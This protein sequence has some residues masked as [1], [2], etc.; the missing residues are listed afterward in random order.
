[1]IKYGVNRNTNESLYNKSINVEISPE[2][3][4]YF[5]FYMDNIPDVVNI[6][7]CDVT[8]IIDLFNT[9]D[10]GI[11]IQKVLNNELVLNIFPVDTTY[12]TL[13]ERKYLIG[14]ESLFKRKN[15]NFYQIWFDNYI[16]FKYHLGSTIHEALLY[17]IKKYR[18]YN[19][20]YTK[21][22]KH[23][24]SL[25][26][27]HTPSREI[28]YNFYNSLNQ[29][30]KE[31]FIC[32]F[33]FKNIFLENKNFDEVFNNF[34]LVF[35]ESIFPYY[36]S[37]LIEI[38]SESSRVAVTE[39]SFK[40][41]LAGVPFIWWLFENSPQSSH[42]IQIFNSIG[43]DTCYFNI[44][45]SDENNIKEKINELLLLSIDEIKIKYKKDFEKAEE[46]KIKVFDYID[47][48]TNDIIK[49]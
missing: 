7:Y 25:N 47:G 42:Q 1:M 41:L 44:D 10:G 21:K 20:D 33:R 31:K 19:F 32:S 16:Q 36:D 18:N 2:N 40:P 11:L 24:L 38:V 9:I 3:E 5:D 22:H 13:E 37:T 46:N 45:Y 4:I 23:F 27:V 43:I 8:D 28:L 39:K 26:N 48:I 17:F 15:V 34:S 14:H 49:K 30:D 35:G 6:C 29:L 12:V